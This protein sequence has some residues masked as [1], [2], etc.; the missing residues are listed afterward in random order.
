MKVFEL[1]FEKLDESTDKISE[2]LEEIINT[3]FDSRVE[4]ASKV[5]EQ[6]MAQ[7]PAAGIAL[8]E[9]LLEQQEK[10]HQVTL[11][12]REAE[13]ALIYQKRQELELKTDLEL[14]LTKYTV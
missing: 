1:G 12:E 11:E 4:S 10:A 5:I 13:K 9:N 14:L 2:K 7:A 3:V 6:A 8:Y